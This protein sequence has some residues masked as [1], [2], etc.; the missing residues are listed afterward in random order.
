MGCGDVAWISFGAGKA[1]VG[2]LVQET[3]LEVDLEYLLS[4]LG[5]PDADSRYSTVPCA[6]REH[7]AG[8]P[9]LT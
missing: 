6:W 9:Y 5:F 2:S 1:C 4:T 8:S 7:R 3:M